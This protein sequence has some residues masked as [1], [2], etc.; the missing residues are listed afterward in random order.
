MDHKQIMSY[1]NTIPVKSHGSVHEGRLEGHYEP[2]KLEA[3]PAE[4]G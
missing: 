4:L 1:P 2:A 3:L